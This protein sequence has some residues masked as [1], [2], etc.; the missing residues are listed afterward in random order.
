MT[1]PVIDGLRTLELG[2]AG[3]QR[4]RL[5]GY[6]LHGRKRATAGVVA[7]Y[8]EEGEPLERVG[9]RL[10][11]VDSAGEEIAR[12]AVTEVNVRRFDDVDWAFADDEGEGFT[13]IEDW[14]E[15]HRRHWAREGRDIT[16]DTPIVCIRFEL[17]DAT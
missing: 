9:E 12:I 11:L 1:W 3:E 15:G 13:S 2:F 8:D 17:L 14:R 6:V 16:G 7:E 4:D 5:T 10:V